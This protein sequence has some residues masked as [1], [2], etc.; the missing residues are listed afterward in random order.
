LADISGK[1]G[2]FKLTFAKT[3][4]CAKETDINE[5]VIADVDIDGNNILADIDAYAI[6]TLLICF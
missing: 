5:N 1:G 2:K 4:K 6:K 3:V